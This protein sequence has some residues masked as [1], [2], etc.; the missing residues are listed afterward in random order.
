MTNMSSPPLFCSIH[1][2]AV[3]PC[4]CGLLLP[5]PTHMQADNCAPIAFLGQ[6]LPALKAVIS[7]GP[8]WEQA[9]VQ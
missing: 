8:C 4:L 2:A 6:K 7:S 9:G 3:E 5:A 1:R